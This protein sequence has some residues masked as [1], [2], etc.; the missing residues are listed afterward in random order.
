MA[1]VPVTVLFRASTSS[2]LTEAL[3][4]DHCS[5]GNLGKTGD[6]ADYGDRE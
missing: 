1:A 6:K 5:G 2:R 4:V 3:A